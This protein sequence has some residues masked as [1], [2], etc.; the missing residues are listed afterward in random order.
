M[1]NNLTVTT[2]SLKVADQIENDLELH[3]FFKKN[4]NTEI[5]YSLIM[6]QD[7]FIRKNLNL[8]FDKHILNNFLIQYTL[9]SKIDDKLEFNPYQDIIYKISDIIRT[10]KIPSRY[11]PVMTKLDLPYG[12]ESS[13]EDFKK[14][15]DYYRG[16][17]TEYYI[18]KINPKLPTILDKFCKDK[19]NLELL[20][21]YLFLLNSKSDGVDVDTFDTNRSKILMNGLRWSDTNIA[22]VSV[23]ITDYKHPIDFGEFTLRKISIKEKNTLFGKNGKDAPMNFI[24]GEF[25][26]D[27]MS[28]CDYIFTCKDETYLKNNLEKLLLCFKLIKKGDPYCPISYIKS[29]DPFLLFSSHYK[30]DNFQYIL[31]ENDI[32]EINKLFKILVNTKDKNL[33]YIIEKLKYVLFTSVPR[34]N[35]LVDYV[36][37]IES[38][39]IQGQNELGFRFSLI[40]S[41]ILKNIFNYDGITFEKMKNYYTIRSGLVHSLKLKKGLTEKDFNDLEAYTMSLV[42]FA[43]FDKDRVLNI[44]KE[45]LNKLDI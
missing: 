3:I 40:S 36:S 22:P 42:K 45:I 23:K 38:L 13:K 19:H 44:E 18:I 1:N 28:K 30:F 27:I 17:D 29:Y 5:N 6:P 35:L 34:N 15:T 39:L 24:L 20:K 8:I 11:M 16:L 4:S 26:L 9:A 12:P 7:K 2:N 31:S 41:Y 33:V 10:E 32:T 21:E 25:E 43:L 37:I 14:L